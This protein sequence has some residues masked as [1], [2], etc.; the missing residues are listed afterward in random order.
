MMT[1]LAKTLSMRTVA[2]GVETPAQWAL[3]ASAGCDEVQGFLVAKALPLEDFQALVRHTP[4]PERS[5]A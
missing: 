1:M 2:E 4:A 5:G 3:V